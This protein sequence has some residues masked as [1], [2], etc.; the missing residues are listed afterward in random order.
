MKPFLLKDM[1]VKS[2]WWQSF[3]KLR[4]LYLILLYLEGDALALYFEVEELKCDADITELR[5][6]EALTEGSFV[7]YAKL[8]SVVW[9]GESTDVY[10][11]NIRIMAG[12]IERSLERIKW[13]YKWISKSHL[14]S[15]ATAAWCTYYGDG[16]TNN[17]YQ[18]IG[19]AK[20]VQG[21]TFAIGMISGCKSCKR[22]K[23]KS[24]VAMFQMPEWKTVKRRGLI[25]PAAVVYKWPT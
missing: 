21:T 12:F 3:K 2:N 11:D 8:G 6:K 20:G 19:Q 24:E 9:F 10:T 15:T 17:S 16:W 14:Y 5:L 13:T 22:A 23:V 4:I 25:L 1:S 18:C 7:A